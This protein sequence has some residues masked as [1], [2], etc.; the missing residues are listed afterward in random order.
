MHIDG[1]TLL[2][3]LAFMHGCSALVFVLIS[4][5]GSR[6]PSIRYWMGAEFIN[7]L[8]LLILFFPPASLFS[9]IHFIWFLLMF[10]S[11]ACVSVGLFRY[12]GQKLSRE[13]SGSIIFPVVL[14]LSDYWIQWMPASFSAGA[15]A[16]LFFFWLGFHSRSLLKAGLM[17]KKSEHIWTAFALALSAIAYASW[18]LSDFERLGLETLLK[19]DEHW[20]LWLL[21]PAQFTLLMSYFLLMNQSYLNLLSFSESHDPLTG[22]FNRSHFI[23]LASRVFYRM[24][25]SHASMTMLMI[26]ADRFK[27]IN[28]R[29]GNLVGDQLLKALAEIVQNNLRPSDLIGRYGGEKFCVLLEHTT[30]DEAQEIAE[31]IRL[32]VE[33]KLGSSHSEDYSTT[34]SI[35]I[36]LFHEEVVADTYQ[37]IQMSKLAVDKAKEACRFGN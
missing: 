29:L 4:M 17:H 2:V 23:Q 20:T 26:D 3:A 15:K 18:M 10:G 36:A 14:L 24:K 22:L 8:A 27:T 9:D 28:Y 13:W 19:V 21:V 31:R 35:G 25:K 32:A 33:D 1:Y 12:L 34:V 30:L 11:V 16:T 6:L 37:L 5:S 7:L